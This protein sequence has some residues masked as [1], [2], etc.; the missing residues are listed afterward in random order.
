M[1]EGFTQTPCINFLE[2][3]SPVIKIT[4]TRLLLAII[5]A[6]HW[7]VQQLD[8]NRTF[9]HGDHI[10]E[11]YMQI[12]LGLNVPT[13]NLVCKLEKSLYGLKQASW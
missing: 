12:A 7:H 8:V 5:A 3:F 4:T 1:A 13:P 2:T 6:K 10:E 11:V 9:L